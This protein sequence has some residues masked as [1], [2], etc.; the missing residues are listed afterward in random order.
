M[1]Y[2][3]SELFFSMQGEGRYAGTPSLWVRSFGC[4]LKCPGFPCDTEYS[5]NGDYRDSHD[6][7]TSTEIYNKLKSLI[8]DEHNPEG[9]LTHPFTGN[10]IHLVFTGGE[11]LLKKYQLM[12]QEVVS[13]FNADNFF[14]K[15]TMETNGTQP[16]TDKFRQWLIEDLNIVPFFSISP[17]LESVSGEVDAVDVDNINKILNNFS[18]QLK[19]VADESNTCEKELF[20]VIKKIKTNAVFD[21]DYWVMPLGATK[22]QNLCVAPIVEKYQQLGFKIATRN[23]TYIWS[24]SPNR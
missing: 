4:N 6:T 16:L 5:W 1:Q 8:T 7:Y 15:F 19:F 2:R 11:P 21:Y 3:L 23:H 22:E 13:M 24:D 20:D 10:D 12:I 14:V 9:C 18:G 17:K